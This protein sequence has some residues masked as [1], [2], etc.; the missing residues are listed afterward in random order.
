MLIQLVE[1]GMTPELH[2]EEKEIAIG[3]DLG[4]THSVVAYA[5]RQTPTVLSFET[6]EK[7]LPSIV[8]YDQGIVV[9]GKSGSGKSIHS[10]KRL[11]GRQTIP[12]NLKDHYPEASF[13][14]KAIKLK[15][16]SQELTPAEISAEILKTIKKNAER[17]LEQPVHKVVITVPAYFD[18]PAR[19]E[20]KEAAR[21]AGLDVLRLINEPTA[22]AFAY[23]LDKQVEGIY[24][25]YD[26]GG[27]TFDVSL[28]KFTRGVFQVLATSGDTLLG[29]DDVDY[30]VQA[31]LQQA[32]P[33]CAAA[34]T[35]HMA[36]QMKEALADQSQ[37]TFEIGSLE[38]ILTCEKLNEL[39]QPLLAKTLKICDQTMQ[40]AKV[41][42]GAIQGVILVGGSTRLQVI[43]QELARF[44]P[45]PILTD[46][47]PDEVV[48]LG[49]AL[50]AE[51]LT[52]GSETLL[53][54]ITPLSLGIETMGGLVEKIIERNT[55]LP[56]AIAQE[57]TTYQDGQTAMKIHVVQGER[58]L[59]KDCRSLGDFTL[60]GIPQMV[61][62]AAKIRITF[63]L[64]ADGLLTVTAKEMISNISQQIEINPAYG[65]SDAD[66]I[67]HLRDNFEHG[68][69]DMEQ[70]LLIEA[71]VEANQLLA[72]LKTALVEDGDL[73]DS[74]EMD[75]LQKALEILEKTVVIDDR[76]AIKEGMNKLETLSF[77]FAERRINRSI[78]RALAGQKVEAIT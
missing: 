67:Q 4:T 33:Q 12:E 23:G 54:D 8:S 6:G 34:I 65:L 19:Q 28:L 27:G 35:R 1:P 45:C 52:R 72:Q 75:N 26:L 64:D 53:L 44:F 46:I 40:D 42:M 31:Y 43:K 32:Y 61:A 63:Q 62:G 2:A 21:L 37:A 13:C 38:I 57:F 22:A 20:T 73:L 49:A 24:V 69:Q 14:D 68:G 47:N 16:N 41:D 39:C 17:V 59:V 5:T 77:S 60:T 25:V 55:P 18:E 70:R 7:L 10:I 9:G 66:M 36:R 51:A 78:K 71:R 30:L 58:E 56:A 3:I 50:Q 15:I 76:N 74:L 48:A 11:I 29:G